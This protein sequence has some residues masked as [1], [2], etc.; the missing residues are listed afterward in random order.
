MQEEKTSRLT[1]KL[2][3]RIACSFAKSAESEEEERVFVKVKLLMKRS[4]QRRAVN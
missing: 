3:K 2:E 4:T 1:R